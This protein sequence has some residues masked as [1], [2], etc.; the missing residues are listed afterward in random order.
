MVQRGV[1]PILEIQCSRIIPG[2]NSHVNQILKK[3]LPI[4]TIKS[5]TI[6]VIRPHV[7][8]MTHVIVLNK[9]IYIQ[10]NYLKCCN[11]K[12]ILFLMNFWNTY[13]T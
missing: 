7:T 6:H 1:I 8:H 10:E 5:R 4:R 2:F 13:D 12:I 9:Q 3:Y 11:I